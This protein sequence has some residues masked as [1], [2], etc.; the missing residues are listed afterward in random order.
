MCHMPRVICHMSHVMCHVSRDMQYSVGQ[1]N[2]AEWDPSKVKCLSLST[3]PAPT[4]DNVDLKYGLIS[5]RVCTGKFPVVE[6][7]FF[8]L[9]KHTINC[10]AQH[11]E[12]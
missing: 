4:V 6:D 12:R 2:Y 1:S 5:N 9:L 11:W 7:F 3:L 8:H 10:N